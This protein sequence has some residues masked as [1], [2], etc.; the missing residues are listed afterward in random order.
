MLTVGGVYGVV[1]VCHSRCAFD[2]R[3][4]LWIGKGAEGGLSFQLDARLTQFIARPGNV[5]LRAKV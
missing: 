5:F 2:Y 3:G 4:S 1:N